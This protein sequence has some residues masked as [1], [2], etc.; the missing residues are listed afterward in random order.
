MNQAS[1][2]PILELQGLVKRYGGLTATDN[3][4]LTV[5]VGEIHAIIGPNGAGKTTLI[6]QISG[7]LASDSG[8]ISF[9]GEDVT[10][11]PMHLR[12]QA[13][14]ARSY[15]I[16]NIFPRFS[17]LDNL[18]LAVQ[19]RSGS[20]MRFWRPALSERALFDEA[21]ELAQRVG[22]GPHADKLA[23]SLAH[24]A[25]RQLELG[26]AL[27][28]RPRLLLLDEPMAGMGHEE[29][30]EMIPLIESLRPEIAVLII[31]HDMDAVFRMADRISVLVAGRIIATGT[32]D[33]IRGNIEVK[34]AYLGDELGDEV[35]A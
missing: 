24:G 31:E 11:V 21:R 26:L 15:Q 32:P 34:K 2:S 1:S 5:N 6:H 23:G 12:V 7:A 27:A 17:V 4:N 28:T 3:L 16:T 25:Q 9:A 29:S 30:V 35:A 18:A 13:G 20:S 10:R 19:A 14:L 33:Q 8:Q 22:L